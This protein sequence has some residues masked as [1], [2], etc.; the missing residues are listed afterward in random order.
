MS[1]TTATVAEL[2]TVMFDGPFGSALKT[3]DYTDQG[4]RV[5]RLEN[6]GHLKFREELKSFV[7]LT[8]ASTL[9]RHILRRGD[10][11]FSSFVDQDTRVCLLPEEFDGR[12]INKADCFCVRTNPSACDPKF[13]AYTLAAPSSYDTFRGTVRGVTRPRIGLR[14]LAKFV[15]DL[16]PLSEQRRIVAKVDALT[17]RVARARAEL[18]RVPK[19]VRQLKDQALKACFG[20]VYLEQSELGILLHGIEAGKNMRCEERPPREDEL[21]VVKVSA[22]T[23]GRFDPSQSKT[24]PPDYAPPEKA[25]IRTGDLLISR[26]NTLELVGA[27]VLV[28]HEPKGLFLSDKILRLVLDE[29]AKKW[30]LWFLRSSLGRKQIEELA[31]GNQLSMRNISQDALR[32]IRLPFPPAEVRRGLIEKVESAFARA[33]RLEAE[34]AR[35]R[36]LLDRLESSILTKAFKGELVPQD[37]NDEPASVLLD[38]IRAQRAAAPKAKRKAPNGKRLSA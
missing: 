12:I 35:A 26:A 8:K 37:P 21:G 30:V 24:L 1:W 33:D 15:I 34:A 16:P 38:R 11:L 10:V 23:W 6:I 19:L 4:V 29:D 17:A 13:L 31:T 36:A 22:V 20:K 32:R 2:A 3:S 9:R 25:R 28:D 7:S 18:D 5:A 27:V 14:D